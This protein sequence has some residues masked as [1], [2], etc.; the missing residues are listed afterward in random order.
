MLNEG[1]MG[2]YG[3]VLGALLVEHRPVL[4]LLPRQGEVVWPEV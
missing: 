3:V 4:S 2:E 1:S